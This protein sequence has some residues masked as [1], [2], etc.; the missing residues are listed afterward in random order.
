MDGEPVRVD[1]VK[2]R[3]GLNL[4]QAG[5]VIPA[6]PPVRATVMARQAIAPQGLHPIAVMLRIFVLHS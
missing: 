5:D 1:Q 2:I 3:K 6:L 4:T